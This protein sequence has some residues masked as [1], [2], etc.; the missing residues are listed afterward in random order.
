M[1]DLYTM[2]MKLGKCF[3]EETDDESGIQKVYYEGQIANRNL[4]SYY[5]RLSVPVLRKFASKAREG[6]MVLSNHNRGQI[7][8]RSTSGT[9]TRNDEVRSKFYIQKD[10]EFAPGGIFSSGGYS[11][12]NDYIKAID[13][14]TY[15]DLSVGFNNHTEFCDYCDTQIKGGFFFMGC[16][17]GH[18]PGQTIY[19]DDDGN[20]YDEPARG[21]SEI[22]ITSEI[23][24]GDL[25]EYSLVDIGALPGA[26]VV[27][28]AQLMK[29]GAK[30]RDYMLNRYGLDLNNP[31]TVEDKIIQFGRQIELKPEN[32]SYS[33]PVGDQNMNDVI[34]DNAEQTLQAQE[35]HIAKLEEENRNLKAEVGAF[36]EQKDDIA[37]ILSEKDEREAKIAEMETEIESLQFMKDEHAEELE[38]AKQDARAMFVRMQ[39]DNPNMQEYDEIMEPVTKISQ[40][41]SLARNWRRQ[42]NIRLNIQEQ[43]SVHNSIYVEPVNV[44]RFDRYDYITR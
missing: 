20:E 11:S 30:E 32:K 37:K 4:T 44:N 25:F 27:K 17:N 21:R 6:V 40:A 29:F 31:D 3:Q 19:V 13:G 24:T 7:V 36:Q 26:E 22:L 2:S 28:Q 34:K 14:G 38:V 10:L 35:A 18:Y 16:A 15:T 1:S 9:F 42:G 41:R 23:R 12:T 33:F 8:G 43:N 5:S 39:G